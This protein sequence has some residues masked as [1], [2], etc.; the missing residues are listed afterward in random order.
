MLDQDFLT[1]PEEEISELK[2]L[3]TMLGGKPTFTEEN[4]A[5]AAGLPVVG[6]HGTPDQ[7]PG[8]QL[9]RD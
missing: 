7:S 3:M 1:I 4:F 9:F 6:Y 5:K 2:V 8:E